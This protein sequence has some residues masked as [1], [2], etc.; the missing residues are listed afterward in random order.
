M[1]YEVLWWIRCGRKLCT[2][3]GSDF[4]CGSLALWIKKLKCSH[5]GGPPEFFWDALSHDANHWSRRGHWGLLETAKPWK[6][7]SQPKNR[8]KSIKTENR[9]QNCQNRFIFRPQLLNPDR[10]DT[11]VTS[12]AHRV[13]CTNF[14]TVFVNAMDWALLSS[15]ICL[16]YMLYFSC[17]FEDLERGL[18]GL[19][20]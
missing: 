9:M 14:I 12:G 17:S 7:S 11:V 4:T 2:V 6:K 1:H 18:C 20:S 13:N 5:Q 3:D 10:S 15:S 8:S 19:K 16:S